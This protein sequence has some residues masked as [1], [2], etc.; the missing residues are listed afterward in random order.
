MDFQFTAEELNVRDRARAFSRKELKPLAS[1]WDEE[2][3]APRSVLRRAA[4]EGFVGLT[5]PREYGGGGSGPLAAILVIE[6]MAA[7]C[8]NTAEVVFDAMLGPPKV[9]EHFGSERL[10]KDLLPKAVRGDYYVA[11]AIS[12]PHAGSGATDMLS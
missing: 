4:D 10:R 9:I 6:E 7:C 5:L 8:A 1:K 11:I 2:E 3:K 12:E